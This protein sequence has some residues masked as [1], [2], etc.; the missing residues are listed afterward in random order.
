MIAQNLDG[1]IESLGSKTP[2]PIKAPLRTGTVFGFT[3]QGAQWARM[4]TEL[5]AIETEFSRSIYRSERILNDLGAQWSLVEEFSRDEGSSNLNDSRFGQPASTA[6][7]L[8]L[9]DLLRSW[10][11]LP[12]AVVGHSSGE[13]AAAYAV[14][15]ITQRMAIRAAYH[16]SFLAEASKARS[17]EMGAMMAVGLGEVDVQECIDKLTASKVVV[18]CINSPSSTTVSGDVSAVSELKQTLDAQGVFTRLLKVDTAYHSH[19][20]ERVSADYSKRLEGFESIQID[21]STRFF[22]TVT[23]DEKKDDFGAAYWVANLVSQV[24]FSAA[25]QRLCEEVDQIH[26]N[27]IEVGP[28]KALAGPLRQ[29]LAPLQAEILSHSYIPT[30]VRAKD[31]RRSLMETGMNLFK[32]GGE[33]DIGVVATLGIVAFPQK[34]IQDLPTYHWNHSTHHWTE[35]RLSREYR[36]RRHPHHDLLGSRILTSPDNQPNWRMLVSLNSLPWLKDHVVDNF[37]VFPAACYMTMAIE[38][39][40]QLDLDSRRNLVAKGYRLRNVSFKTALTIPRESAGIE[41][42]L[43][44]QPSRTVDAYNFTVYSLSESE[45]WQEACDGTI[46]TTFETEADEVE[47]GREALLQRSAQVEQLQE[48]QSTSTKAIQQ[49][50]LYAQMATKGNEYGPSFAIIDDA[51]IGKFQSLSNLTIPAVAANMP[52][53]FLQPHLIHPTCLDAVIQTAVPLFQQHSQPGSAMPV[54]ISDTFVSA[55]ITNRVGEQLQV[56]CKLSDVVT[57]S[58]LF[59]VLV[60]QKDST[61]E[62]YPVLTMEKGELRNIGTSSKMS[63]TSENSNIFK[64]QWGLDARSIRPETLDSVTITLQ[65]TQVG[66]SQMEKAAS[67]NSACARYIDL[68]VKE[69]KGQESTILQD[70][71]AHLFRWMTGF[72]NSDAG[73]ALINDSPVSKD[74]LTRLT[75]NLGVEGEA[76]DRFG[77]SLSFILTGKVDPL[78]LF[79]EGDLLYRVYHADEYARANRYLAEYAK[80][81]TFQRPD[82]KIL[83]IGAGTGG[84]TLQLLQLCSPDHET[85]C[86]KYTFTDISP[87]FFD[88][89]RTTT[90]KDWQ[91]MLTFETLDL[92]KDPLKQGFE[93]HEYDF[94]IAANVVHATRSLA[95][96]LGRIRRLL[97][98]GGLLGLVEIVK[99]TPFASL[100]FGTLTGWWAGKSQVA[101]VHRSNVLSMR[102]RGR[103][104]DGKPAAVD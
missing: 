35:S 55:G 31:S 57:T 97:K 60:F 16:R 74:A 27:F 48:A 87:G 68:C 78:S 3:G 104:Q 66:M 39:I 100:T 8:A 71:R 70:H 82:L 75:S 6:I 76:V 2:A 18:A 101:D 13:I 38:A 63:R 85:F 91:H 52:A 80:I 44:F 69:M 59:S 22:S 43:T 17:K 65:S 40:K 73:Q 10:N 34:P 30:L 24:R 12:V 25:V 99:T 37:I 79:L 47:Q 29:S 50:A 45:S 94:V 67:I 42:H 102:R 15:A 32:A 88:N 83:E 96:S 62:P 51:Q 86:S 20:M 49:E 95:E 98:P 36:F 53:R 46:S 7:Q 26:L 11:V 28:H 56:V 64:M 72:V 103:R 92:E 23:A 5:I 19:H 9:V 58:S 89:V 33:V 61:G 77:P 21:P 84:T 90:L 81:L 54:L 93:E 1:L 41:L 14:G 4:G